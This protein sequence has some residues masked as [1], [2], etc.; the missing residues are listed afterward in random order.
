MS[1]LLYVTFHGGRDGITNID[2]WDQKGGKTPAITGVL[3]TGGI[4]HALDELRGFFVAGDGTFY[5]ADAYKAPGSGAE[6]VGE[7]LHFDKPGSTGTRAY[8]GP[9]CVW[10]QDDNSG[11]QH[12]FDVVLGPDGNV[13]V[14]NQG[15]KANP[16]GTNAVTYYYGPGSSQAGQPMAAKNPVYPG[17]F[18]APDQEGSHGAKVLRDAIFGPSSNSQVVLYLADEERNEVRRYD[19][20]GNYL[21]SPVT[22]ADGLDKPVHLLV[23]RG[24][25]HL[26]IGS[27]RNNSVLAFEIATGKTTTLVDLSAGI[28]STGGMAEDDDGWLY[29]A[30][31]MGKEILRFDHKT[32]KPD[33]NPFIPD[34]MDN[35]EFVLWV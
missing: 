3:E 16:E 25:T 8:L 10:S 32:G 28:N 35:P 7:I 19:Q 29:V 5:L 18:I 17:T 34:L 11:L 20:S 26:Y 6:S 9:F 12:P 24:G 15:Q 31:R 14:A 1:K 4:G 22:A 13:Y 33:K 23:S 21:D 30:S 2:A 27:Q